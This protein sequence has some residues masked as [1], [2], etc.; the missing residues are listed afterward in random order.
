[1]A[2][3]PTRKPVEK[4]IKPDAPPEGMPPAPVP[5]PM[6]EIVG[7]GRAVE[8]LQ[9]AM[10]SGRVHHAWIFHGPVGVGKFTAALSFAATLLDPTSQAGLDGFIEPEPESTVQGLLKAGTH[11]DLHVITKELAR[12]SEEKSVRDSKLITIPKDVVEQRLIGPA[13]LRPALSNAA[14]VSKVFIVDEAELLDRSPTNAPTQNA[15]LKTLEEPAPR[16]VIILVTSGEDRLL[17]TIRSRCQRVV[18]TPL[19]EKGM[20]EWEKS[21]GREVPGAQRAWLSQYA[22]GSPGAYLEALDNGLFEWN[23]RLAPM[24][25]ATRTGRFVVELGATMAELADGWAKAWVEKRPNAS[26]DSANKDGA[27]RVFR[28]ITEFFRREAST[29]AGKT[30][31]DRAALLADLA[32]I[33]LVRETERHVDANVNLGLAMGNLSSQLFENFAGRAHAQAGTGRVMPTR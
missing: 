7:Q 15:I 29:L 3:R 4:V 31:G 23:E 8:I 1:M 9:T 10:K 13:A 27:D 14:L 5:V 30:G 18:F 17:P 20:K 2:K 11:P 24:L 22:A 6:R 26:K 16:T 19:D 33:D 25:S 21:L 28:L 12:F 32:A